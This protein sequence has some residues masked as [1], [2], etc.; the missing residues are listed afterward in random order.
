MFQLKD[1]QTERES[2][3]SL[4]LPLFLPRLS[5]DLVMATPFGVGD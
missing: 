2:E 4:T 1:S 5:M 3:F